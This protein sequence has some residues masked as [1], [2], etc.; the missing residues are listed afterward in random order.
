MSKDLIIS[1]QNIIEFL[2]L[3]SSEEDKDGKTWKKEVEWN[4]DCSTGQEAER[5]KVVNKP[6]MD[7][8]YLD[9]F[10]L[11]ATGAAYHLHTV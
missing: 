6:F 10:L 9:G 5:N 4:K 8:F 11:G 7:Y 1:K 3:N 2:P